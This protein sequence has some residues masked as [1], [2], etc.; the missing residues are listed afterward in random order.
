MCMLRTDQYVEESLSKLCVCAYSPREDEKCYGKCSASDVPEVWAVQGA[1]WGEPGESEAAE[2]V[3]CFCVADLKKNISFLPFPFN[4]LFNLNF[5][6]I[7]LVFSN[8]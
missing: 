1:V 3:L 6:N 8:V 7:L 5:S 4:G 2:S